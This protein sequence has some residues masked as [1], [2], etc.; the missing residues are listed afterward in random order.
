MPYLQYFGLLVAFAASPLLLALFSWRRFSPFSPVARSSL[1]VVAAIVLTIAATET[2]DWLAYLGLAWPAW[3]NIGLAVL[4]AAIMFIVL[5]LSQ[6]F[7]RR[8]GASSPKQAEQYKTILNLSYGH[9]SFLVVTAAV[10]EEALYRGYAIG[11]GQ[12]LVG[13]IWLACILSV[14]AFTLAHIRWS[15]VHL[16]PVFI[17]TLVLTLLFV[18]THNLWVCII[19]HAIVDGAG[20][21]VVPVIMS[22]RH[23]RQQPNTG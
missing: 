7:Q 9:R 16:P 1:W 3:A 4:A 23:P 12:H 2:T 14:V 22:R 18:F 17:S 6:Y 19:A 10:T 15:F 5:G 21:L 13:S 8:L 20:F 11:V